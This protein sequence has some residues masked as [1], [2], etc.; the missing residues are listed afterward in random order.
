MRGWVER[1]ACQGGCLPPMDWQGGVG[2]V[3]ITLGTLSMS[4]CWMLWWWG[5]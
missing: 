1:V 2:R 5:E 3:P 4:G